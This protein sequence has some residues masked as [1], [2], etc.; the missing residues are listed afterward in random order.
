MS[1]AVIWKRGN[2]VS[3]FITSY[4]TTISPVQY[5]SARSTLLYSFQSMWAWLNR[6]VFSPPETV[7]DSWRVSE[8][9]W[10]WVPE[11]MDI[12]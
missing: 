9:K 4:N 1:D 10:K 3:S 6:W 7:Y 5:C 12:K 2:S 11:N 8:G